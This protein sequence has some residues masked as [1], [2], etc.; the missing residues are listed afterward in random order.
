MV[1]YSEKS[2]AL[3]RKHKEYLTGIIE[4]IFIHMIEIENEITDE[5]KNPQEGYNDNMDDDDD[6]ETT[7]FGMNSIDRIIYSGGDKEV[8][9]VLSEAI[10]GLLAQ[11]DWRYQYTAVMALSQVG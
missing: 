1:D 3:F 10:K 7:K 2:P 8:L 5:W 11:P 6:Y 9:P 4:M